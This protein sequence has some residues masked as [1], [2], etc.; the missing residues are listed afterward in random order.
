MILLDSDILTLLAARHPKVS[1]RARA[2]ATAPTP[3]GRDFA[4]KLPDFREC[5]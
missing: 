1:A 4:A 3:R 2:A 5:S